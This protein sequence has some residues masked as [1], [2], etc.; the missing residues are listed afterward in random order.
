M[1]KPRLRLIHCSNGIRPGAKHRQHGRSFQPLIIHG[2]AR[3]RSLPRDRPWE[4]TLE[5]IELGFSI[6]LA[7][8]LAFLEG[9]VTV[10]GTHNWTDF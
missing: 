1:S 10:L 6:F 5:L 8:Y 7:N 2:G 3:A 9:S 4:A